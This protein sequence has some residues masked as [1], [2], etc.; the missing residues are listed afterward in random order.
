MR[1]I[2]VIKRA[3]NNHSGYVR[4]LPGGMAAGATPV[5]QPT[6]IAEYVET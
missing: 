2:V 3:N 4:D 1:D 5:P 6:S